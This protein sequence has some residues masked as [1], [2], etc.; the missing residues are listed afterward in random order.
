M[1]SY[2]Y[3]GCGYGGY[4]LPKDT[5]ALY[6][7]AKDHGFD[8]Q[9]LKNVIETNNNMP[10]VITER[11][12]R[13]AGTDQNV[14][15]GILGLSFKPNSDDTRDSPS[16]KIIHELNLRGYKNILCYD[17]VAMPEFI[18]HYKFEYKCVQSFGECVDSA[19]VLVIATAWD[20]FK[21]LPQITS[22]VIVDCRYML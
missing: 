21:N 2:V 3:P 17:P 18:E 1:T 6:A 12:I 9:I 19:N 16:A 20:E 13:A 7:L 8:A 22:K 14:K 5:S 15:I 11:I 4:C 10:R